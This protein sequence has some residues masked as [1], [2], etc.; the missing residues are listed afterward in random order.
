MFAGFL[1]EARHGSPLPW[2]TA[3]L[4]LAALAATWLAGSA[5]PAWV[6][7]AGQVAQ[8][9]WWRLV[10][11]HWVHSDLEHAAW[12][13]GALALLGALFEH[14]LGNRMLV[15]LGVG[16]VGVDAWLLTSATAP[17]AYCGLSGI[18]N[19]LLAAGLLVIGRERPHP[20]IVLTG[21]GAAAKILVEMAAGGALFT[22]TAWPSVPEAHAVGFACG[23][24]CGFCSGI[25]RKRVDCAGSTPLGAEE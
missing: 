13:I 16:M 12:D 15:V 19:S 20:V 14:R 22:D 9:E 24:L 10:T 21:L 25:F 6:F 23:L 3:L 18:L 17:D 5:P 8:G 2:R 1:A 4:T 7:D 11:G